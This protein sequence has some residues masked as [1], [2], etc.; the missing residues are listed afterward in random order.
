MFLFLKF[1]KASFIE[2]LQVEQVYRHRLIES[3]KITSSSELYK[4]LYHNNCYLPVC[5]YLER[6]DDKVFK[7]YINNS[8]FFEISTSLFF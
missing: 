3:I 2:H 4:T 6:E 7:F 8:S 5:G 1:P